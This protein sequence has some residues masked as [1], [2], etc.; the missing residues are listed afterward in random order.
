M[1]DRTTLTKSIAPGGYASSG[2][3]IT[4]TAADTVNKN[5]FISSGNDLVI[6]YNSSGANPYTVTI[7]SSDDPQGRE[8]D[9][10]TET[11][12]LSTVRIFGPFPCRGW[13]LLTDQYI[14]LEASNAAVF[15][16]VIQLP[17]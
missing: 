11:I 12:A 6:A 13:K 2:V 5:R 16:G 4:M 10:T 9:I 7:E 3:A 1:A 15:F 14:H 8:E 17:N